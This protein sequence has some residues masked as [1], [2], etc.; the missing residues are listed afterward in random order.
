[1]FSLPAA[2]DHSFHLAEER[3]GRL[4]LAKASTRPVA[5]GPLPQE[6]MATAVAVAVWAEAAGKWKSLMVAPTR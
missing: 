1:M 5:S 3:E 4:L 6:S 2:M